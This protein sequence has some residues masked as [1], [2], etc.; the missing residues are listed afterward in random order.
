MEGFDGAVQKRVNDRLSPAC[1]LGAMSPECVVN[2][3]GST[4]ND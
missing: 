2:N 1:K 4:S 3:R